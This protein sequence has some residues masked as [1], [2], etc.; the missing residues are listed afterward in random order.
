MPN[1]LTWTC[2]D[3]KNRSL[4]CKLFVYFYYRR[5]SNNLY[6]LLIRTPPFSGKRFSYS[7]SFV[8]VKKNYYS[9]VHTAGTM[10]W[11]K[12]GEMAFLMSRNADEH[13]S[14]WLLVSIIHVGM[15]LSQIYQHSVHI[16]PLRRSSTVYCQFSQDVK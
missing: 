3:C 13:V 10:R 5:I 15:P 4:L 6:T 14:F 2:F 9:I 1:L 8:Y 16:P 11:C 7:N 12:Y